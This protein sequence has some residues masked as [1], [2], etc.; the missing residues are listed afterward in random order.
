[1]DKKQRGK[2]DE[3]NAENKTKRETTQ[4]STHS[5]IKIKILLAYLEKILYFCGIFFAFLVN[6]L[7]LSV[8]A[9]VRA[10]SKTE[11]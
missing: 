7:R 8:Y 1:M 4:I 3:S 6:D 11:Y 5:P 10:H 9:V 2:K